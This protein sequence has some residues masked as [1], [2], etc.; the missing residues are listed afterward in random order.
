MC[1]LHRLCQI[2]FQKCYNPLLPYDDACMFLVKATGEILCSI[3][4]D[5]YLCFDS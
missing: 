1:I 4:H 3:E 2:I 5:N